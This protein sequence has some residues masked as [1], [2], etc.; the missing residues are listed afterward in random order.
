MDKSASNTTPNTYVDI[1]NII[2]DKYLRRIGVSGLTI[3][4]LIKRH[5]VD[6]PAPGTLSYATIA[7]RLGVEQETVIRHVKKL[8]SL[9]LLP[10]DLRFTEEKES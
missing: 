9:H 8:R 1:E 2:I 4:T 10:P 3:Y 5:L 6:A 7:H